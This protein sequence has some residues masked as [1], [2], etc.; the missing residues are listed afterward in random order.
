MEYSKP[1]KC[2]WEF[3]HQTINAQSITISCDAP[4]ALINCPK[5]ATSPC[6][7]ESNLLRRCCRCKGLS[8]I[9]IN[10]EQGY[11]HGQFRKCYNHPNLHA[12]Q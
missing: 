2:G 8:C 10:G 5:I 4:T 12:T 3:L 9:S 6:T 1:R 7:S 11:H